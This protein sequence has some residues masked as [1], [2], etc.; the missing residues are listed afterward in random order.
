VQIDKRGLSEELGSYLRP[1]NAICGVRD[2]L[3]T[4]AGPGLTLTVV[5]HEVEKDHKELV[6]LLSWSGQKRVTALVE[7][8]SQMRMGLLFLSQIWHAKEKASIL[9]RQAPSI[10]SPAQSSR[11]QSD[12]RR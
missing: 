6:S 3:L 1:S 8:L 10:Q 2:R 12:Q 9:V 7:H 11:H 5:I 4:A